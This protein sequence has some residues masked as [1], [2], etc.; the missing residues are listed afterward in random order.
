MITY[1]GYVYG[2]KCKDTHAEPEITEDRKRR[3][4]KKYPQTHKQFWVVEELARKGINAWC[5]R[6]IDFYR[7]GKK[8][9]A[10]AHE[11]P[12]LPNYVFIEMNAM[13]FLQAID[14]EHLA[15]T[16]QIIPQQE[17]RGWP[18]TD[19][20]AAKPGLEA[21]KSIIEENYAA[22][23]KVDANSKAAIAEYAEGQRIFATSGPFKEMEIWFKRIVQT[24]HDDWPMI[25][26]LVDGFGGKVPVRFDPLDVRG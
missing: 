15:P 3:K 17:V 7:T 18:A 20:S 19:G 8:R 24:A 25:E 16:F 6:K 2:G 1:L 26:G 21:F 4:F 9:Y 14:V 22:A 12:F 5:G 10:E 11:S 23:Q 13:Q